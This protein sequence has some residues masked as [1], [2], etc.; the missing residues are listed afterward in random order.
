MDSHR[1]G[2][3]VEDVIGFSVRHDFAGLMHLLFIFVSVCT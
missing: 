2:S 3:G 1:Y